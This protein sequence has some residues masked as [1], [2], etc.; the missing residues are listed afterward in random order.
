MIIITAALKSSEPISYAAR[1]DIDVA[2]YWLAAGAINVMAIRAG[3]AAGANA[4]ATEFILADSAGHYFAAFI[5]C[6]ISI[7]NARKV[8]SLYELHLREAT[9]R[10]QKQCYRQYREAAKGAMIDHSQR[11]ENDYR[12]G[13]YAASY[14]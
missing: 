9:K 1:G 4:A 6:A 7:F 8:I 10:C 3:E 14:Y 5:A 11:S 2:W 13:G 12:H